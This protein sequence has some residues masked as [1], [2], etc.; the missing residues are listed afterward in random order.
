M[1][2]VIYA[3]CQGI[4]ISYFLKKSID[5]LSNPMRNSS[6]GRNLAGFC[7]NSLEFERI[8]HIRIDDIVFKKSNINYNLIKN[9]D[10][11]IYQP[12]DDKHG[13]I[14]TNSILKLLKPECKKISFPYIYNNSFYP[15]IGPLV[16]KDSYRSKPCS[17]IFNNSEIITDLIDKK[18]NLNE[19]LKLYQE[20]KINFNYQKRWDYTNNILKEKEKNCDVKIVDF[21]KNNFSKQRLFLLENHPTSII[22]INVVNQILEKL[23]IPVKINPTNYNLND[24]NLSGGLI[25]LDD[26]SNNF[27]NYEF[28]IEPNNYQYYKQI[29]TNIYN[30]YTQK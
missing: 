25:P 17:V 12:L 27:F 21:I 3:N 13:N 19:I 22:F 20:N 10:I 26:S 11:F 5:I 24:A 18:Y 2:I 28:N 30:F 23:E 16:I 15:V 14:S 6:D 7:R 9:A 1:K 4:G 29:I 8:S